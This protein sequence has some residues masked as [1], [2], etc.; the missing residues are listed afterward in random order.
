[1]EP[2]AVRARRGYN[3]RMD[4]APDEAGLAAN[5]LDRLLPRVSPLGILEPGHNDAASPRRY[6][7]PL[8]LAALVLLGIF[9]AVV[10]VSTALTLG[11]FCLTTSG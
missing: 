3:W 6:S 4:D 2:A 7:R 10:V 11:A 8:R 1:M 5:D 9:L